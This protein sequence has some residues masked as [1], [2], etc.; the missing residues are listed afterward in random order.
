MGGRVKIRKN[1]FI[2]STKHETETIQCSMQTTHLETNTLV[3]QFFVSL[4]LNWR[5]QK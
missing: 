1:N 5:K 3:K 4:T 2:Q